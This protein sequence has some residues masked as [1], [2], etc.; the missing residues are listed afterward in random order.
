VIAS[1]ETTLPPRPSDAGKSWSGNLF[2]FVAEVVSDAALTLV[3]LLLVAIAATLAYS[4]GD[5]YGLPQTVLVASVAVV[6]A[7]GVFVA[8]AAGRTQLTARWRF[9]TRR[10]NLLAA[11]RIAAV[12][13]APLVIATMATLTVP[14]LRDIAVGNVQSVITPAGT[15]VAVATAQTIASTAPAEEAVPTVVVTA[16]P[17][18][19]V[20]VQP[21]LAPAPPVQVRGSQATPQPTITAIDDLIK[22]N[23]TRTAGMPILQIEFKSAQPSS[24]QTLWVFAS[25][26]GGAPWYPSERPTFV[27]SQQAWETWVGAD[28]SAQHVKILVVLLSGD[29]QATVENYLAGRRTDKRW[30][31]GLAQLPQ[32]TLVTTSDL[33]V[34]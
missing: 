11:M 27:P 10:N 17:A 6:V 31:L 12:I 2:A 34:H 9:V 13:T 28:D 5:W 4:L 18:V 29:G 14:R 1:S 8:A 3:L 26:T 7:C 21:T 30:Y 20:K 25:S 16:V 33:P 15:P 32:G 24:D 22:A 23:M 19:D